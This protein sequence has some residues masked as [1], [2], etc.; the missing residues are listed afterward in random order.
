MPH[1]SLTA[2][3]V[4]A[5]AQVESTSNILRLMTRMTS[6]RFAAIAK[7]TEA[8]WIA[9]AVHDEVHFGIGAGDE[10][11]LESTLCNE[12]RQHHQRIVFEHASADPKFANHPIPKQYGIESYVSIPI[13]KA[14][15]VFFGTLCAMD[16][17][18]MRFADPQLL[19]TLGIF[20]QLIATNL[21][22]QERVANALDEEV[23]LAIQGTAR[24]IFQLSQDASVRDLALQIEHR[25]TSRGDHAMRTEAKSAEASVA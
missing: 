5:I 7:V 25:L 23:A 10:L 13:I 22:M 9:C 8:Q 15:G 14:D 20:A 16:P 21:D 4:A 6:L 18:P 19:E 12:V 2:A 3:E 24:Q 11:A 1:I 17:Q